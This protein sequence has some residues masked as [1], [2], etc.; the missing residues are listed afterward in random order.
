MDIFAAAMLGELEIVKTILSAFPHLKDSGG[1]HGIP[2]IVHAKQGGE[3]A[4]AVL[5]YL[6]TL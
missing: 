6:E 2:L 4:K 1:A 5:D 3:Q